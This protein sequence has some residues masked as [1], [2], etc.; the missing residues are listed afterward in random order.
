LP[1]TLQ[2]QQLLR[3][4]GKAYV[5]NDRETLE[6][7]T[8]IIIKAGE[9]T[10]IDDEED[11]YEPVAPPATGEIHQANQ[12]PQSLHW[13]GHTLSAES[14]EESRVDRSA[15][16]GSRTGIFITTL[17]VCYISQDNN[18]TSLSKSIN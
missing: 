16:R 2:I 6:R 5:F 4:E 3:R 15:K 9:R 10:G 18:F 12:A 11:D 14:L 17:T 7:V 8:Q 13:G 1:N